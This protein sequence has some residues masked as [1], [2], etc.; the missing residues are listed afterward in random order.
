MGDDPC[1]RKAVQPFQSRA[2]LRALAGF[3]EGTHTG[4]VYA[5]MLVRTLAISF[6]VTLL[7]V[8]IGYPLAYAL[9]FAPAGL[10]RPLFLLSFIPLWMSLLG[11]PPPGSSCCR[12]TAWSTRP[13]GCWGWPASRWGCS[14]RGPASTSP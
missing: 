4:G 9:T 12:R 6:G 5:D 3:R 10:K 2:G 7:T 11:A 13:Q 8:L 14:I 1:G